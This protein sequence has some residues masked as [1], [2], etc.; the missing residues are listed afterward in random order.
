MTVSQIVEE[1]LRTP[2]KSSRSSSSGSGASKGTG[3]TSLVG[4]LPVATSE[5]SAIGSTR[6]M[7]CPRE[8]ERKGQI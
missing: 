3:G 1:V 2:S 8:T 5:V 7:I 6:W 4:V